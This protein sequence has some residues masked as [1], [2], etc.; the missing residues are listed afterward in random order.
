[1]LP[2]VEHF[3]ML[4]VIFKTAATEFYTNLF[5]LSAVHRIYIRKYIYFWIKLSTLQNI[6][7][8]GIR[9]LIYRYR[10]HPE[11]SLEVLLKPVGYL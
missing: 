11:A 6:F 8:L 1:M 2:Q 9:L 4:K 5:F 3:K 7:K 10:N